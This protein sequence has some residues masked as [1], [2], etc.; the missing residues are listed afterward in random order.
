MNFV[1]DQT[2]SVWMRFKNIFTVQK[3]FNDFNGVSPRFDIEQDIKTV[4]LP[5][6]YV[7]SAQLALPPK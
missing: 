7:V 4:S 2:H 5:P 3:K 1:V 6:G